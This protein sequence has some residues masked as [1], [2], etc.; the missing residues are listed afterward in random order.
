[1]R[2]HIIWAEREGLLVFCDG[3]LQIA[4]VIQEN[5]KIKMDRLIV[6]LNAERFLEFQGAGVEFP[7]DLIGQPGVLVGFRVIRSE[8][9]GR[10][11]FPQGSLRV[12]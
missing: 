9:Q 12:S 3:A 7:H 8:S 6:R 11:G 2:V 1:M 4:L 10:F 5:A